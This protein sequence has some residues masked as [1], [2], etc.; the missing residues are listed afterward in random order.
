MGQSWA[1]GC[2]VAEE[3]LREVALGAGVHAYRLKLGQNN[4]STYLAMP[5]DI[6]G[7]QD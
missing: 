4:G 3:I 5:A 6:F 7:C 1:V 2:P